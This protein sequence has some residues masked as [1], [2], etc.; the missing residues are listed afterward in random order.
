[1]DDHKTFELFFSRC[2][3]GFY[4]IGPGWQSYRARWEDH[5]KS[6]GCKALESKKMPSSNR[7]NVY[8]PDPFW[9]DDYTM[10]TYFRKDDGD[11]LLYVRVPRKIAEK[12]LVLGYV[13]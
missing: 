8:I 4:N 7:R 10:R 6:L 11:Y 9:V 2:R 5:L 13:P 1:M 12:V 3:S